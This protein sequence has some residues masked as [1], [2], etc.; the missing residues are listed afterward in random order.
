M[1]TKNSPRANAAKA[2]SIESNANADR[3]GGLQTSVGRFE[4][5]I[6]TWYVRVDGLSSIDERLT[7]KELGTG[8]NAG[9]ATGVMLRHN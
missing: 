6:G 3:T 1:T 7:F 9:I 5:T 8:K 4:L 2:S